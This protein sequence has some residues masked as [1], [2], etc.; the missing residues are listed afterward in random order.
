MAYSH[1]HTNI[2]PLIE[3]GTKREAV[4]R[5]AFQIDT[6]DHDAVLRFGEFYFADQ[7]PM[8]LPGPFIQYRIQRISAG[9]LKT[10]LDQMQSTYTL[11]RKGERPRAIPLDDWES[12]KV[13]RRNVLDA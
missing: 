1:C 2:R 11:Y 8:V 5:S 10:F 3:V 7:E 13:V 4:I 9:N 12:M 6:T